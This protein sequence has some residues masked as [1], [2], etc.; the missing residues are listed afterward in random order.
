MSARA[1]LS[2]FLVIAAAPLLADSLDEIEVTSATPGERTGEVVLSEHTGSVS[3]VPSAT[4]TRPGATLARV[5]S[6]ETGVQ[7]RQAGGLGSF[8]S[9]TLRGSSSDQVMV[10]L[11]GLLL[12]DTS[13]GGVDLSAIDLL[14]ARGVEIYRGVTP[15]QLSK[16]SLGGAINIRTPRPE[17]EPGF[18]GL[19]G[20][21]SF[22]EREAALLF[23]QRL[24]S[25]DALLSLSA[26]QSDND[27]PFRNGNGT[28]FTDADDFDD[29]RNNDQ[30]RQRSALLKLGHSTGDKTRQDLGFQYFN[31]N[32]HLPDTRNSPANTA[33][34]DTET[35][36]LQARHSNNRIGDSAWNTRLGLNVSRAREVFSDPRSLIGLGQQQTRS[37]TDGAGLESYWERIGERDSLAM[38]VNFRAENYRNDDLLNRVDKGRARRREWNL[39]FQD[40]RFL[41]SDRWLVTPELRFQSTDD[42]FDIPNGNNSDDPTTIRHAWSQLSPKIGLRFQP[43]EELSLTANIGQYQRTPSFFELFGD[44]G[45]FL[46]NPALKPESGI[47]LDLGAQWR[48]DRSFGFVD[49]PNLSIALFHRDVDNAISRVYNARGV[50]KSINIRGA[51]ASGLE[52]EARAGLARRLNLQFKGTLQHTENRSPFPAF[53]GKQLPGQAEATVSLFL[54][55]PFRQGSVYYEYSG[56]FDSYYDTANLLPAA[57]QSLHSLG[58]RTVFRR[59]ALALEISNLG[60]DVYEDFNGY[61]KPGRAFN[62]TLTYTGEANNE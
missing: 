51:L 60:N 4:L 44:R 58:I 18:R 19:V 21:G 56:R 10:Y 42:R 31:K 29:H 54:D 28:R 52:W 23:N 1:L 14:Q 32:Q 24:G 13:G 34:L 41:G 50:G 48:S 40:A 27:F 8:S 12:N 25:V 59:L 16:A 15:V 9:A 47:N 53:H 45:L 26:A 36:R 35:W 5:L 49:A 6:R 20:T 39:A 17:E 43:R 37:I 3:I 38:L 7:V 46:G 2:A 61:P 55:Y 57:D 33:R 22:H 30:T 62:L 11:D